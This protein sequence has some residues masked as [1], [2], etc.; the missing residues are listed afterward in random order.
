M[1]YHF[2]IHYPARM[3]GVFA[4]LHNTWWAPSQIRP[5]Q[6]KITEPAAPFLLGYQQ[7]NPLSPA[8]LITKYEI[9]KWMQ[10]ASIK[11]VSIPSK[12]RWL[13]CFDPMSFYVWYT[14]LIKKYTVIF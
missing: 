1:K 14:F 13:A 9:F 4:D 11:I 7:E 12:L 2:L 8:V 3:Q 10:I 5:E 6:V